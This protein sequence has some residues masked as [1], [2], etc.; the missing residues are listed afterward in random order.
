MVI[1]G[2]KHALIEANRYNDVIEL[3]SKISG[4]DDGSYPVGLFIDD[5]GIAKC[6]ISGSSISEEATRL[7]HII[8]GTD[9]DYIINGFVNLGKYV[10]SE[11]NILL[12][13]YAVAISHGRTPDTGMDTI[14]VWLVLDNLLA[15]MDINDIN[16]S[17]PKTW[18]KVCD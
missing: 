15:C 4:L 7:L 16:W 9:F 6:S 17:V 10:E 18:A 3:L 1:R 12:H 8:G 13:N 11:T 14:R 5:E 2:I